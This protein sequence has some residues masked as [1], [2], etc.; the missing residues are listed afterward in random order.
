MFFIIRKIRLF[1]FMKKI[2]NYSVTKRV[3]GRFG[4]H[5]HGASTR[6]FPGRRWY[7]D[8]AVEGAVGTQVQPRL[9]AGGVAAPGLRGRGPPLLAA[10]GRRPPSAPWRS[11]T[12]APQ[13]AP[14]Q[15]AS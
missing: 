9:G 1:H 10:A 4:V 6:K 14:S 11:G 15:Q 2:S 3:R 7:L 5:L 13:R 12:R 8:S